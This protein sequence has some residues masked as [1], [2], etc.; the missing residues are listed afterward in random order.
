MVADIPHLSV[1]LNP[2]Y[3]SVPD[4]N[5]FNIVKG[6]NVK[7][8]DEVLLSTLIKIFNKPT[9][10]TLHA[11]ERPYEFRNQHYEQLIENNS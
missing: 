8:F 10:W 2:S 7:A 4:T 11:M 6:N 1:N 3:E 9:T 5:H